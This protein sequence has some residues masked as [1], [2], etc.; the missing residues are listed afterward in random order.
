MPA[1]RRR[2]AGSN[3][4]SGNRHRPPSAA[5]V[6]AATNAARG[7]I[8]QRTANRPCAFVR[9][10][11]LMQLKRVLPRLSDLGAVLAQAWNAEIS[12]CAASTACIFSGSGLPVAGSGL[13]ASFIAWNACGVAAAKKGKLFIAMRHS[14]PS[15]VFSCTAMPRTGEAPSGAYGLLEGAEKRPITAIDGCEN[16]PPSTGWPPRAWARDVPAKQ[17]PCCGRAGIPALACPT[18]GRSPSFFAGSAG[19]CRTSRRPTQNSTAMAS[20]IRAIGNSSSKE[21]RCAASG[22]ACGAGF[23]GVDGWRHAIVALMAITTRP[24]EPRKPRGA[25]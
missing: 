16:A 23:R 6:S 13:P 17:T 15:S 8:D 20:R 25:R 21:P 10:K 4:Q 19:N 12:G 2:G 5:P 7:R 3:R 24:G 11:A 1:G 18:S 14:W 9:W 22:W